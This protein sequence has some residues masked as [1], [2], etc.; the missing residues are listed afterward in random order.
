MQKKPKNLDELNEIIENMRPNQTHVFDVKYEDFLPEFPSG[1]N[2]FGV[3][4][5]LE[6]DRTVIV[7]RPLNG[8]ERNLQ[9]KQIYY[10]LESMK[11]FEE[12]EI[13][14][15]DL[16]YLRVIVSRFNHEKGR[17][18]AV[19]REGLKNLVFENFWKRKTITK[20][21]LKTADW[22]TQKLNDKIFDMEV[23]DEVVN[24]SGDLLD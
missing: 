24:N 3:I 22:I 7:K 18:F 10:E 11:I 2:P 13:K 6:G 14:N 21:E 4:C 9:H 12:K 20:N 17:F 8:V 19:R 23:E 16:G 15:I 5:N 1:V